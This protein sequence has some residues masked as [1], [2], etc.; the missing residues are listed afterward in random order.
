M[1]EMIDSY[2]GLSCAECTY[3]EPMHCGG[4]IATQG[5]PFHGACEVAE[6]AKGRGRRFCGE[7]EHIPCEILTRYSHDPEHGDTPPGARIERCQS[8]KRELVREAREGLD[9]IAF[10]GFSC[11]HCFLGQWCGG[12]R[13]EYNCCSY[14]TISPGGVCENVR[15]AKERNLYGC[16]LCEDLPSCEKGFF[17]KKDE[18][19]AKAA[20]LFLRK[21]GAKPYTAALERIDEAFP[22]DN[23]FKQAA[24]VED[25]L[26]IL[27]RYM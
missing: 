26:A 10:C 1:K 17:E 16:Y 20:A 21:H 14:A 24:S 11:D 15:C 18:Y 4:C 8:I 13:S 27:E 5:K 22:G 6:C 12:C 9:P 3:R 23:A 2:C 19:L 25:A 7:C